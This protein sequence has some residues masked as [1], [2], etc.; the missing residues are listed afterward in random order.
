MAKIKNKN[1]YF[2]NKG[3]KLLRDL[4]RGQPCAICGRK[5][6][7]GAGFH[8]LLPK[9]RFGI[10]RFELKNLI[11]LCPNCHC[12]SIELAAHSQNVIAIENFIKWMRKNRQKQYG[13][14]K[15]AAKKIK[16]SRPKKLNY[17]EL[18][19]KLLKDSNNKSI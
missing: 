15:R 10:Y 7:R 11:I 3:D 6:V 18:Y 8:H 13:W 17:E 19:N 5:G 4:A 1:K 14:I 12:Y 16:Q 9:S 2:K